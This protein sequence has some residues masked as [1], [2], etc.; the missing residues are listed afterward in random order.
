MPKVTYAKDI[1]GKN[2]TS[3]FLS[4]YKD[5]GTHKGLKRGQIPNVRQASFET[6]PDSNFKQ[7]DATSLLMAQK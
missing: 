3:E 6:T 1:K 4:A 7:I 2:K 5:H